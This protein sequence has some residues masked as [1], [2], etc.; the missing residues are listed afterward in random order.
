[1]PARA[2]QQTQVI[3]DLRDRPDGRARIVRRGFLLDRDRRRQAL[4]VI[5]VRLLHHRQEL[6]RVSR[7]RF[8]VA[9][10][11]FRVDRV[12]GE[13]GLAGA[14]QSRESRSVRSLGRSRSI[15]RR[16]WVRAPRILMFCMGRAGCRTPP[17]RAERITIR[18]SEFICLCR[19]C[20]CL[21]PVTG[22]QY[23]PSRT[24]CSERFKKT[25]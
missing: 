21:L 7:E 12:E 6:P 16:L 8:D 14:G 5:D 11:A 13:R 4:D 23:A 25:I 3:V 19:I 1:M 20:A 18:L 9:S 24:G 22:I 2:I 15:L 17:S 10:L